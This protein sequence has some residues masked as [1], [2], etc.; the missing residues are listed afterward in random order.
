MLDEIRSEEEEARTAQAVQ[1]AQQ[2]RWTTWDEVEQRKLSWTDLWRMEP[3]RLSFMIN[4]A[5]DV[6]PTPTNMVKWK[7]ADEESCK[8]CGKKSNLRHVLSSCQYALSSGRYT[9][10]HN[11]VL[12][13][14]KCILENGIRGSRG[15]PVPP[16]AKQVAFVKEGEKAANRPRRRQP[17]GLP[18]AKD[19][20]ISADLKGDRRDFPAEIAVSSQRPDITVWS[21]ERRTAYLIELTV[22]WEENMEVAHERKTLR[23]EELAANARANGWKAEVLPV[24]VGCRGFHGHSTRRCLRKLT[25]STKEINRLGDTAVK[26][27]AWIWLNR[28]RKITGKV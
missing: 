15:A 8:L 2:G 22:P 18:A 20:E 26:C 5:Y 1:Q 6:L 9:W 12:T 27:S 14:L 4:A 10:R 13:A 25:G 19:W 21:A 11:Q 7:V 23:Y 17:G 16:A 28:D 24:E 3:V